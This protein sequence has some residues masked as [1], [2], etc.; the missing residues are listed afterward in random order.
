MNNKLAV[1]I[2]IYWL[3]VDGAQNRHQHMINQFTEHAVNYQA[4]VTAYPTRD[5]RKLVPN[6]Q[7]LDDISDRDISIILSHLNLI[8]KFY[9]ETTSDMVLIFEDDVDF[10]LTN[11]WQF[12]LQ[13]VISRLP[14]N[15]NIIQ[16]CLIRD[17]DLYDVKFRKMRDSD[18]GLS[19]Y[20][21]SR[22]YAKILIDQY[23]RGDYYNIDI[24]T[25]H[26]KLLPCVEAVL[27]CLDFSNIYTFPIFKENL[28]IPSTYFKDGSIPQP[29]KTLNAKS[30][31]EITNWWHTY[32]STKNLDYFF[33]DFF[34]K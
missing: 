30:G 29:N 15:W 9:Y 27:F 12:T 2:P 10:S 7:Y 3:T 26:F 31:Q 16:L 24:V 19:S 8:K 4:L 28:N 13:D 14:A 25:S 5:I 18:W 33:S 32:G 17:E 22:K 20:M 6:S 23:C 1:S 34:N 21:V 11:Y